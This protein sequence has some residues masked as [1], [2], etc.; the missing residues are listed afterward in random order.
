[1][2]WQSPT[3]KHRDLERDWQELRGRAFSLAN[4][5]GRFYAWFPDV[6]WTEMPSNQF[7]SADEMRTAG[8]AMDQ[9]RDQQGRLV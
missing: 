7:A 8:W 2:T 6:V 5:T 9:R 4:L 3:A 1:M